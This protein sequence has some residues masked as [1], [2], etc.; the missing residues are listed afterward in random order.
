MPAGTGGGP[1]GGGGFGVGTP[2]YPQ[3]GP[4]CGGL[5]AGRGNHNQQY[6]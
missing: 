5:A 6:G 1:R 4:P 2:N 3:G